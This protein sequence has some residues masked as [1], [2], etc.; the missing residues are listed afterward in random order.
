MTATRDRCRIRRQV[1]RI[2]R[3]YEAMRQALQCL[4]T[5]SHTDAHDILAKRLDEIR[6]EQ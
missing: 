3:D 5:L 6:K 4:Q 2:R 1:V